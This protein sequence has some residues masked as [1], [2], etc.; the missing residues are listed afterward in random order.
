MT[1]PRNTFEAVYK[2]TGVDCYRGN[3]LIDALPPIMSIKQSAKSMTPDFSVDAGELELDRRKRS[4][5][6]AGLLDGFYQPLRQHV[7]LEE[8]ISLILRQGYLGRNIATGAQQTRIQNAYERLQR[9]DLEAF[10]FS[11]AKST[12]RHIS[13]IGCSGSGKTS[14]LKGILGTYPQVIHH[15]KYNFR[16][17]VYLRVDCPHDGALKSLCHNFFRALDKALETTNYAE[18][19]LGRR[20]GVE[21]LVQKMAHYADTYAIGLLVIDE[22]QH[23][24]VGRN[25]GAEK[26]MNFFV[27]LGNVASVPLV[28]VGTPKARNV[29]Q[30]DLRLARRASGSGSFLWEPLKRPGP[31][32][33]WPETDWGQFTNALWKHQWLREAPRKVPEEILELWHH[34]SQGILDITVKLFVFSQIR[35]VALGR[36]RITPE[37][38]EAVFDDYLKPIHPMIEAL[39]SGERDRIAQYGDL[40]LPDTDK[41]LIELLSR[42]E[43]RSQTAECAGVVA[44]GG[45]VRRIR[46]FLAGMGFDSDLLAPAVEGLV[47]RNPSLPKL[48]LLKLVVGELDKAEAGKAP[49]RRK[50]QCLKT[51]DW[52]S[53]D[54]S[55]I[56]RMFS[57]SQTDGG[58]DEDRFH[59]SLRGN[60]VFFDTEQWID[61]CA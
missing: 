54:D 18:R 8:K 29:L 2:D 41:N 11:D 57:D 15:K 9:G 24:D 56:R 58:L 10:R 59:R 46:D 35:A 30:M 22:M 33:S 48:E 53:L 52:G 26:M 16:Q 19:H 42:V 4:H 61:S 6:I 25:G 28:L 38:M 36:E 34:L 20:I 17:V 3:P 23:L 55:D 27:H 32:E 45:E 14:A 31:G 47:E 21:T 12:A 43:D 50:T 37:L 49:P 1:L 7:D 39:R 13:L 5:A 40:T 44:G 51:K 60:G